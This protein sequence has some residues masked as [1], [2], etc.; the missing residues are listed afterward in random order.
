MKTSFA[1]AAATASL[2]ML[3][4]QSPA[5]AGPMT[6]IAK[7]DAAPA[8]STLV[9]KTGRRGRR[10][11]AGVALGLI[12]AVAAAHIYDRHYSRRRHYEPS[13]ESRCDRWR[14]WCYNGSDQACWKF[15]NRC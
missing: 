14:R 5:L 12:G 15:E 4:A 2:M 10:I 7:I 1:T 8:E 9:H 6:G 11:A 3:A 13:Y